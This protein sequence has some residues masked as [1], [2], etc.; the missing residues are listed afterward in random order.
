MYA[1]VPSCSLCID[2]KLIL[3]IIII[4]KKCLKKKHSEEVLSKEL[5]SKMDDMFDDE[6]AYPNT[7]VLEFHDHVQPPEAGM[8]SRTRFRSVTAEMRRKPTVPIK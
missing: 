5:Q 4:F 3:K 2:L 1:C 8:V 7:R 6:D